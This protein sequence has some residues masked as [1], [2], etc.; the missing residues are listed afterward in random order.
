MQQSGLSVLEFVSAQKAGE[1]ELQPIQQEITDVSQEGA[2]QSYF[3]KLPEKPA[4]TIRVFDRGAFYTVHGADAQVAAQRVFKTTSVIRQFREGEKTLDYVT[5][6]K[7][8]F[9]N[10]VKE[11]L[12]VLRYRVEVYGCVGTASRNSADW[13]LEA[14]ASP[15]NLAQFEE[16]L[17]GSSGV[18]ESGGVLAIKTTQQDNSTV[19]GAAFGDGC[20]RRLQV[21]EFVDS[22][23]LPN[24]ETLVVQLA[25]TECL[26][27]AGDPAASA[28]GQVM[29]RAGVLV[30]EVPRGDFSAP[31]ALRDLSRLL[32]FTGGT[33]PD[34]S[35][36]PEAGRTHAMAATAALI[37][38][39]RLMS[40]EG[41]MAQFSLSTFDLRQYMRLDTAAIEAFNLLPT[42]QDSSPTHSLLGLLDQCR[43]SQGS[44]LLSQWIKQPLVDHRQIEERL[45]L[46]EMFTEDT[47]LR[48]ALRDDHLRRL[49]DLQRLVRRLQRGKAGLQDC[50]RVYQAVR[51]MPALLER[52]EAYCGPHSAV[53]KATFV[54]PLRTTHQEFAKFVEMVETTVDLDR[55]DDGDYVVRPEFDDELQEL[56]QKLNELE[57]LVEKQLRRV[58]GDL[59]LEPHKGIKLESTPQTGF[60]FRVLKKDEKLLRNNKLY[61]TVET[62]KNGVK[63]RSGPLENASDEYLRAR[64]AYGEQQRTVIQEIVKIAA[65][66]TEPMLSLGSLTAQLDVLSALAVAGLS[67]PTP[68]VRPRLV[69][70]DQPAATRFVQLRHPCVEMQDGIAYIPN[71]VEFE[72]GV[73]TFK[74][75]TG[76]NMGGKSTYIRSVA[77]AVV[78]AQIGSFVPC[79]AAQLR[80]V[81]ALMARVGAGDCQARGVS[82]FMAEMLE[83]AAI[84]RAAT[85]D[86]LVVIDEL[87][88]GTSTYDG[89][90]L[91]WAIS[92]YIAN[93]LG[94]YT[95]F[96]THFHELAALAEQLPAASNLH[97]TALTSG[98]RL[99]FLYDV[100]PGVCDK[101]FGI[102]VAEL[103]HFPESVLQESRRRAAELEDCY[104]DR[105]TKFSRTESSQ[106]ETGD[107]IDSFLAKYDALA[108]GDLEPEQ[109][110]KAVARLMDELRGVQDPFVT[111]VLQ[112]LDA[113]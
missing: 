40:D 42:P 4:T 20:V 107:A 14:Q 111:H 69:P 3:N 91:A 56:R 49:P 50:C 21:A 72:R 61:H 65:G 31:D 83:T 101:S 35:L 79:E 100:Q 77:V 26:V 22:G 93:E 104:C 44:R 43:T 62:N 84:L 2:F 36:L 60:F 81:D 105:P 48:Q 8:N 47:E 54:E 74:V 30:T 110:Q 24:L 87:G 51:S 15:G 66:Y 75:I 108:A 10:F 52:L 98:G 64:A 103:A 17:F 19:V 97:V 38:Y 92:E 68:Y 109:R 37:K 70:A 23:F 94:A 57:V 67:A 41:S 45:D 1:M 18:Q 89:F 6:S 29:Q 13:R 16:L 28:I 82:T 11:L 96:A 46:V 33:Q 12:L 53:V 85:K 5:L 90:G 113:H 32:R 106:T 99:T 80:P 112:R 27:A 71:N 59:G 34:A 7:L 58:A 86:S 55:T 95:L 88:R 78:M 102:H 9:E 73:S 76:P 25:P 63:F 39:L